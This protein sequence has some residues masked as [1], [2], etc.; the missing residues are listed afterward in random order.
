MVITLIIFDEQ[1]KNRASGFRCPAEPTYQNTSFRHPAKPRKELEHKVQVPRS[2][3]S[4]NRNYRRGDSIME[5][6]ESFTLSEISQ[7]WDKFNVQLR[8]THRLSYRQ[9]S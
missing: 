8:Q 1:L 7:R 2:Q 9:S 6:A 4:T 3:P 5:P